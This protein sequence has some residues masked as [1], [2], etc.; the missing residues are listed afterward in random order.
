MM[1][2]DVSA[3]NHTFQ[4]RV[5]SGAKPLDDGNYRRLGFVD[6]FFELTAF[7]AGENESSLLSIEPLYVHQTFLNIIPPRLGVARYVVGCL[8]ARCRHLI[9]TCFV[10]SA[11]LTKDSSVNAHNPTRNS[12]IEP[13]IWIDLSSAHSTAK[14]FSHCQKRELCVQSAPRLIVK[15][16]LRGKFYPSTSLRGS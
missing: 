14:L 9:E 11:S 6:G 8:S 3:G 5:N 2:P 10:L 12:R 4:V 13:S 16:K 15:F 7:R 1:L